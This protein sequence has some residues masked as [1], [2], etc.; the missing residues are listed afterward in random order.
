MGRST[1]CFKIMA[2]GADSAD[3]V[4]RLQ[5]PG[6]SHRPTVL[7]FFSDIYLVF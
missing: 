7:V 5:V 6:V 3:E 1:S 2:C 4:D